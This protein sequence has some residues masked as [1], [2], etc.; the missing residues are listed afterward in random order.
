VD[1]IVSRLKIWLD[2]WKLKRRI[3]VSYTNGS[4]TQVSRG[5]F[6][7]EKS[8]CNDAVAISL[9]GRIVNNLPVKRRFLTDKIILQKCV[10][11][12]DYQQTKGRRSE[13]KIPTGKIYGFRKFD[14]VLFKG[15]EYFVKG[16]RST[17]Y[18]ELMDIYGVN[19]KLRPMPKA[20]DLKRILARI[21]VLCS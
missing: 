8:H 4:I 16:R 5:V 7:L 17:G 15:K 9:K 1:T 21:S 2:W 19:Q 20:K 18:F 12:G 10:A 6:K 13:T 11:K 3:K 14:K